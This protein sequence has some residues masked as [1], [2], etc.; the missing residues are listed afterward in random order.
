MELGLLVRK[1]S[2]L[3]LSKTVHFFLSLVRAKVSAI[4][5]G[6]LGVGVINQL[7]YLTISVTKFTTLN[8][9]SA[10]VKNIASNRESEKI[11]EIINSTLKTFI[12]LVATFAIISSSVTLV[13]SKFLTT[14]LFGDLIYAKFFFIAILSFPFLILNSIPYSILQ[15]FKNT[16][17]IA[18][19]QIILLVLD[20]VFFVPLVIYFGLNGAA[21]YAFF[22][23]IVA[24]IVN[25]IF[26]KSIYFKA[27]GI[28]I[29]T[30]FHAQINRD[31]VRELLTF[32]S[33]GIITSLAV[34][35][36]EFY[37]RTLIVSSVGIDKI[38]VYSPVVAWAGLF[39]GFILPAFNTYLFPRYSESKSREELSGIMNDTIRFTTLL[40]IPLL[41]IGIGF[42]DYLIVLLYND[43]FSDAAN[44]LP[45]HF[46]GTAFYV[47][48]YTLSISLTAVNKIKIESVFLL[49]FAGLN[50][51]TS[52]LFIPQFG[53]YGY[54]ARNFLSPLI[55]FIL[56]F[57]Y[58][59]REFNFAILKP[60]IKL[61]L[62]V[63]CG[64][65]FLTAVDYFLFTSLVLSIVSLFA[66]F[67]TWFFLTDSE[68]L[69]LLFFMRSSIYNFKSL[70]NGRK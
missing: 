37:S 48:F 53:L 9:G 29:R 28:T 10:V 17:V 6:P 62:F 67:S 2:V 51:L 49:I 68:R 14:Y 66:V 31:F 21:V 26:A 45:F 47:W 8:M 40:I 13:F 56:V 44:Y 59:S 35:L 20:L 30:I 54:M 32:S 27:Y 15:A 33:Y 18:K 34:I 19:S 65:V 52:Y 69:K 23:H 50:M 61:L 63:L 3:I 70:I 38:G 57:L 4:Y 7:N 58:L 12:V 39:T 42:K 60:N 1:T 22:T 41:F 5:L 46:L 24:L 25:Y 16:R 64:F 36:S 43:D 55:I 11:A